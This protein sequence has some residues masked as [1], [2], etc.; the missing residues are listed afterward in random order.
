VFWVYRVLVKA[1]LLNIYVLR[2]IIL[3]FVTSM[4]HRFP[5]N[6]RVNNGV[7]SFINFVKFKF[8]IWKRMS[9]EKVVYVILQISRG[10]KG[11]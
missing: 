10:E 8:N 7:E 5:E 6:F 3:I 9:I 11:F 4:Y 2:G 1:L